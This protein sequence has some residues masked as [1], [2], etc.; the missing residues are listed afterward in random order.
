MDSVE[1]QTRLSMYQRNGSARQA[2]ALPKDPFLPSERE[3]DRVRVLGHRGVPAPGR[4]DNSVAA[5]TEA[6]LQGADGVEIDVRL[7]ADGTLVCSH[8]P[9]VVTGTGDRRDVATSGRNELLGVAGQSSLATL[10]ELLRAVQHPV[11]GVSVV[12]EA[13]PVADA[14]V[15]ARTAAALADVLRCYAGT[16]A[17]TV[18]SF[19]AD[20][21]AMIRATC[22][23]L[24]VRTALLG[25]SADPAAAVVRR[26]AEDGHDE[27]HLPV[28]AVRRAPRVVATAHRLGLSVTVWTVNRRPDLQWVAELDVDAVITDEVMTAWS[29]LDRAAAVREMVVV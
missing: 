5:V 1:T 20:L 28:V 22:A 2:V 11:G 3:S 27:V 23:D 4:P 19:D 26:A 18:S 13:K 17:I 12:V 6:L 10:P 21:L 25:N 15:A 9:F 8:D 14:A 24:P 29:E 16:A 7:T